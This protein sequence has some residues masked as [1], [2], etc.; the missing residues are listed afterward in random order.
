MKELPHQL[1]RRL[2]S[3][4]KSDCVPFN[5][6]TPARQVSGPFSSGGKWQLPPWWGGDAAGGQAPQEWTAFGDAFLADL[7]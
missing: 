7:K 1:R 5:Q 2:V 4:S 3:P 6:Q